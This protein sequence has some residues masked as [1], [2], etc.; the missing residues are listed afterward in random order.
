MRV[1]VRDVGSGRYL[2]KGERWTR[3]IDKAYDFQK[4]SRAME[5]A[6]RCKRERLEI[7]LA[8]EEHRYDMTLEV[9]RER[10][11]RRTPEK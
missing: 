3:L 4:S 10:P 2:G 5:A 9:K 6:L 8:F 11:R 7:V 1:L